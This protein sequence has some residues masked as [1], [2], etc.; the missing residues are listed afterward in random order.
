MSLIGSGADDADAS[1]PD[2]LTWLRAQRNRPPAQ[3]DPIDQF[4]A[5]IAQDAR[6]PPTGGLFGGDYARFM[7]DNAPPASTTN[8]QLTAGL[9]GTGQYPAASAGA[10][11]SG[12][13]YSAPGAAPQDA[14]PL[15]RELDVSGANGTPTPLNGGST[16][17]DATN[18][19]SEVQVT[20]VP[21]DP[22]TYLRWALGDLTSG[23]I[24][25]AGTDIGRFGHS[26]LRGFA[27]SD[28]NGSYGALSIGA[29]QSA[30]D[31]AT[32]VRQRAAADAQSSQFDDTFGARALTAGALA[33]EAVTGF[34]EAAPLLA[35]GA[36]WAASGL[37]RLGLKLAPRLGDL[38]P[39][40]SGALPQL[41]ESELH[42]GS[43]RDLTAYLKGTGLQAHHLNQNAAYGEVIPRED[44]LSVGIPGNAITEVGSPH[45]IL[46]SNLEDFFDPYRADG[47]LFGVS[48]TNAKYGAALK[49][50]L[51]QAGFSPQQAASIAD[52]AAAQRTAYGLNPQDAI[53]RVPGRLSQVRPQP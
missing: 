17:T 42:I 8:G 35:R 32:V 18:N 2:L 28:A 19:G 15:L 43:Y 12:P 27:G 3:C 10:P 23:D 31:W 53:P 45:Y 37:S 48:P 13:G 47:E 40:A 34:L 21:Q 41:A 1:S 52:Q 24:H 44:G 50:S 30:L 38:S 36:G 7:A 33:P 46:H 14:N 4:M 6:L 29:P 25:Q 22:W 11:S 39:G 49:N 9:S 20:A 26:V 5:Q 51:I 16:L